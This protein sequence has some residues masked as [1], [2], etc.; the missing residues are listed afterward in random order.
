VV[1]QIIGILPHIACVRFANVNHV[2]RH[3]IA[4][5]LVELVESGNLPPKGRSRVAAKHEDHGLFAA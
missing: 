3:L 5:L 2:E 4:I 1:I